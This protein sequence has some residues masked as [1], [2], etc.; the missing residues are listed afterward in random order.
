MGQEQGRH[1]GVDWLRIGAFQL[2]IL[3]HIGMAFVPWD[4]QVKD[5]SPPVAWAT[6]PMLLT[7]PWRLP[8]LFAVSGY[9]SAALYARRA[10][11]ILGFLRSR[12]VRLGVPLL[13]GMAVLVVPQPWVW[14]VTHFGYRNGF[15]TFLL[16]DYYSFRSI[17]GII[18]PT[19]MHLWFVAY[20]LGYTF[21]L[22]ALLALPESVRIAGRRICDRLLGGAGLLPFGILFVFTARYW[23]GP[24]WDDTHLFYND[25]SAHANYIAAFL[26]GYVLRGSEPIRIA[27]STWWKAGAG[28]AFIGW[29][30]LAWFELTYGDSLAPPALW[31]VHSIA[32]S[33]ESWGAIIALIGAADRFWNVDHRWR[34]M[35]AEAVFPFYLIHQTIII[36]VGYWLLSTNTGPLARFLVLLASTSAGCWAF[37]LGGRQVRWLRPLIGLRARGRSVENSAQVLKSVRSD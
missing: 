37:Y 23:V 30:A 7:N 29:L 27:V 34:P 35:L 2:L 16:R 32:R 22:G 14:L 20:L 21:V 1:Y 18:V 33:C 26:F 24:G 4:F 25:W 36:V 9:A 19:W 28:L 12:I 3:Y 10:T 15:A 6:L 5:A 8:L 17:S 11:G 13:F 31:P